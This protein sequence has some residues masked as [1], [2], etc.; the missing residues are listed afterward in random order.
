VLE[1]RLLT[2]PVHLTSRGKGGGKG[3]RGGGAERYHPRK[4]VGLSLGIPLL[5]H[6]AS[7][8]VVFTPCFGGLAFCTF[9]AGVGGVLSGGW[10]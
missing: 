8:P 4:A 7:R 2:S 3:A 10:P 5:L 9:S 1:R 6:E